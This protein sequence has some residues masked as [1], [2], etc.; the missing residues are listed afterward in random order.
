MV[1]N[2]LKI[3]RHNQYDNYIN[4]QQKNH[5]KKPGLFKPRFTFKRLA[6]KF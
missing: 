4:Q 5:S 1:K 6:K 2:I 3:L